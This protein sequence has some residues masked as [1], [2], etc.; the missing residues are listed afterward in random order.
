MR[1]L[2]STFV[3]LLFRISVSNAQQQHLLD[4]VSSLIS[5]NKVTVP[6]SLTRNYCWLL[7]HSSVRV[8][9][10]I[11]ITDGMAK[12]RVRQNNAD[13]F[14]PDF[15]SETLSLPLSRAFSVDDPPLTTLAQRPSNSPPVNRGRIW[16]DGTN[17]WV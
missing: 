1:P 2:I 9:D 4:P 17:F 7:A 12:Y 5:P 16:T 15:N 8:G 6:Y 11:I 3:S 10:S 14:V 13:A